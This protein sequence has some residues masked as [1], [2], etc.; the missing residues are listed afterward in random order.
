[1]KETYLFSLRRMCFQNSYFFFQVLFFSSIFSCCIFFSNFGSLAR[2]TEFSGA[3]ER[4]FGGKGVPQALLAALR[5]T[6]K[7]ALVANSANERRP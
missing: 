2:V 6:N 3:L 4:G 7:C 1:M 5:R